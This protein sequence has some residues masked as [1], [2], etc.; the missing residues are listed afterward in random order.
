MVGAL[1]ARR[2]PSTQML[3][4]PAAALLSALTA[5]VDARDAIPDAQPDALDVLPGSARQFPGS[6]RQ[7]RGVPGMEVPA[8]PAPRI[9]AWVRATAAGALVVGVACSTSVMAAGMVARLAR[10]SAGGPRR[11]AR[12]WAGPPRA[13]RTR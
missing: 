3:R 10:G 1:A 6:A 11:F 8:T 4:D 7:F 12:D 9:G 2:L 13:R 5:D